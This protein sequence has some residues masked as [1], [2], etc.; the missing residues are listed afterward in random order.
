MKVGSVYTPNPNKKRGRTTGRSNPIIIHDNTR[1][2]VTS[3]VKDYLNVN[4]ID[5]WIQ[6]PYSPDLQPCGYNCFGPLK[7]RQASQYLD[8]T[9]RLDSKDF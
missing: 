8:R 3:I 4:D 9:Q 7:Q 1:P 6:P 2:H 5:I